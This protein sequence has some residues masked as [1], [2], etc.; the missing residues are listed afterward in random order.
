MATKSKLERH[1]P[2]RAKSTVHRIASGH[3]A[4]RTE[5]TATAA[6]DAMG[7]LTTELPPTGKVCG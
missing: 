2:A 1:E 4:L 5:L 7:P 3:A 6:S